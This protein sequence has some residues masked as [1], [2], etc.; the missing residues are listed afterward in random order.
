[1]ILTYVTGLLMVI[2]VCLIWFYS[3]FRVTL[4][5]LIFDKSIDDEDQFETHL[6]LFNSVIGKALSCYICFSF[7]TSLLIGV[8]AFIS[9][10]AP[11]CFVFIAPGTYP[12]I[13]YLYK[14]IIDRLLRR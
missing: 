10:L 4:G 8:L 2:N 12:G 6:L 3:P 5:Q 7:W 14:A 11:F 9:G 13:C 1:M